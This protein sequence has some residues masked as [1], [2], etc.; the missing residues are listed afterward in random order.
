MVDEYPP[1]ARLDEEVSC[2]IAAPKTEE[3]LQLGG[4][5]ILVWNHEQAGQAVDRPPKDRAL[6]NDRAVQSNPLTTDNQ[7]NFTFSRL[8]T[9]ALGAAYFIEPRTLPVVKTRSLKNCGYRCGSKN[10]QK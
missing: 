2:P 7:S 5:P 6:N 3:W 8:E 10:N 4:K 1:P 9:Q